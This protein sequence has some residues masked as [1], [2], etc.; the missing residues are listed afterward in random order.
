MMNRGTNKE[1]YRN[2]SPGDVSRVVQPDPLMPCMDMTD[3]CDIQC[4]S[5]LPSTLC[6]SLYVMSRSTPVNRAAPMRSVCDEHAVYETAGYDDTPSLVVF[7]NQSP[8][9]HREAHAYVIYI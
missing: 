6:G 9:A 3:N 7:P 1:Q 5:P 4:P 8:T 2:L